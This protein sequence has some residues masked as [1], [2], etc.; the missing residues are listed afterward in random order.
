M[1][2]SNSNPCVFCGS[3]TEP[4]YRINRFSE[5]FTIL[6]CPKCLLQFQHPL[7]GPEQIKALYGP[8]YYCQE[9]EFQYEDERRKL[10]YYRYVWDKRIQK[11]AKNL[12]SVGPRTMLDMGCS[13]GGLLKTAEC[14]GFE[15][16][17]VEISAYARE[18]ADKQL[19][20]RIF[21]KLEN[22][23]WKENFFDAITLVE[24]IEHLDTPLDTLHQLWHLLKP[25]G[26]LLLQTANMAGRQ[27]KKAGADY[28]YYLPG[29]LFYF[30]KTNLSQILQG[31]GFQKIQFFHPVEF[32]LLAKLKKSR[33]FFTSL[34]DYKK[35]A[36][37]TWYHFKGLWHTKRH[38][39]TSSMVIYAWK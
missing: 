20:G 15:G 31:I 30:S 18:Y 27:A 39:L 2:Q 36:H 29:H 32:G 19:P 3:K 24:V 16:Y 35:W 7:P 21:E 4:K 26:I 37:I 23:P 9:N 1:L 34:K 25:G 38:A 14:Y 6:E 5:P 22:A 13:F 12:H 10:K 28:H 17:G 11:L 8:G 33:G